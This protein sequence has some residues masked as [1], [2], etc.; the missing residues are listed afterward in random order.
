MVDVVAAV[1]TDWVLFWL[2]LPVL[3]MVGGF[4][5][6][7]VIAA[8]RVAPDDLPDLV[9]AVTAAVVAVMS[10]RGRW[11]PPAPRTRRRRSR[12]GAGDE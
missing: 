3:L 5:V 10:F 8:R 7:V 11:T 4:V 2:K 6:V 9:H 1:A 12:K